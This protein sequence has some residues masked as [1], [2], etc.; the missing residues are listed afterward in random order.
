MQYWNILTHT[1]ALSGWTCTSTTQGQTLGSW[2]ITFHKFYSS[3]AV[4]YI[5][6]VLLPQCAKKHKISIRWS[7]WRRG[8]GATQKTVSAITCCSLSSWNIISCQQIWLGTIQ[9]R[10]TLE[11]WVT[12]TNVF[13]KITICHFEIL[14]KVPYMHSFCNMAHHRFQKE[15]SQNSSSDLPE[16]PYDIKKSL[17]VIHLQCE[18]KRV[19]FHMWFPVFCFW[20]LTVNREKVG[21]KRWGTN[22]AK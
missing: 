5:Y 18:G 1:Y 20:T 22:K 3:L 10:A 4:S 14:K 2:G 17:W 12:G 8:F 11:K 7:H 13:K 9:I 16:L 15:R 19:L 21:G 6:T